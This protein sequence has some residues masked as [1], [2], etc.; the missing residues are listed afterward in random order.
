MVVGLRPLCLLVHQFKSGCS[1]EF[2][3]GN[4]NMGKRVKEPG[5][6]RSKLVS[7]VTSLAALL[8]PVKKRIGQ[9][10]QCSISF[11]NES[12][13]ERAAPPPP[14]P[15]P[16]SSSSTSSSSTM[17][18]RVISATVSNPSSSMTATRVSTATVPAA[19]RRDSKLWS[20]T[21][22]VRLGATQPLSPKEIKRQEAIFELAQGEQDLVEDLKLAKKAYHDP[23]LKLSIMTEQELNQIFGTLDSLIPLHED[24][25]SRL[26][27]ARKPDGSTE[28]VGRLLTG[29]LPGL[30][31]Y[32]S[33][34][35]NQVKAK[36]LLDQKKQDRRV[37]DFLQRCLQSPFS[38]KLDLWNFLDIPR[39]RL[40]K[41]PL[42]LRE[43]LKHTASDHPDRQHLDEAMLMVQSVVADINRRTGESECQYYKDRLL[44]AEDGQRDELIA[45][46][47][48]LSCH[49]ELKNNRGLKLQVFLFQDV[50]VITRSA[51]PSDQPISYQLCRQPIPIR[52]L[53][54]EDLSDGEMRVGG[55]IRGAFS[56]NER[57]KNFFRVSDRTGGQLQS[58]CFQASDA[59]NKQQWINCIRQA[60]EAAAL[61]G[62]QLTR[63]QLTRDQLTRDQLTRDQPPPP[64]TGRCPEAG[65]LGET[66]CDPRLRDEDGGE[67]ETGLGSK[68]SAE[69]AEASL[70]GGE[71]ETGQDGEMCAEPGARG[72]DGG[73]ETL[74]GGTSDAPD[75]S[76]SCASPCPE[77][78]QREVIMDTGEVD[79]LRC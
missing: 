19:K 15:P 23:M 25:L 20:E 79:S 17:K 11:R 45:R 43:I 26:R 72:D 49:G 42:L 7:R 2:V 4:N 12:Q 36:A 48:T 35:S 73:G 38:R 78:Q 13:T 32:T 37:Q 50:L 18:R 74:S 6:K 63:D 52:R 44:Y 68:G 71:T 56:N 28:H 27:D 47:R 66:G 30:S 22:D 31:S 29:W 46:S 5:T 9:T 53:D 60:K 16:S 8:P 3:K 77:E 39:S 40:V 76:L 65:L 34:C 55:S 24:L 61:T 51:S 64:Q 57:T 59:F 58:H 10:P 14:L 41:Y 62:D 21:F 67:M 69:E 33:Y 1:V 75:P 70:T 54:L